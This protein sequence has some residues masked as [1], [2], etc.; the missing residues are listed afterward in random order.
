M[1]VK[2]VFCDVAPREYYKT[3]FSVDLIAHKFRV[4]KSERAGIPRAKKNVNVMLT[5]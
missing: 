2:S 5:D 1:T 3:D 4:E